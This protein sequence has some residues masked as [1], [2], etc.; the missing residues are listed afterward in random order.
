MFRLSVMS[1]TLL[2]LSSG[3][4]LADITADDVWQS[5][6]ARLSDLGYE[7]SGTPERDGDRL[8]VPDIRLSQTLADDGGR[9]ELRI[10]R[11]AFADRDD[12]TVAVIYPETMPMEVVVTPEEGETVTAM[13]TLSHDALSIIASGTAER[14]GYAYEGDSLRLALGEVT[15]DG[16]AM[17]G[18]NGELRFDDVSGTS[19][20]AVEAGVRRSAQTLVSGAMS[21]AVTAEPPEEEEEGTL[22]LEGR[23]DSLALDTR[24][25]APVDTGL[26]DL[27][28]ALNAG[29][30][31][32]AQLVFGAGESL[33]VV[34]DEEGTSRATSRSA[35]SGLEL[36][37]SDEG[38]VT[39]FDSTGTAGRLEG[40]D[41]PFPVA[42]EAEKAAARLV[43]PVA[44]DDASQEFEL[45]VDLSD[46]SVSEEIWA[47]IDPEG[48]LPR[49][50]ASL[51]LALSGRGQLRVDIFDESAV[52]ALE[53]GD[54][55]GFAP[56]RLV[57]ERLLLELAGA[58]LTGTGAVDIE[59]DESEGLEVPAAEG[60]ID[61]QL[62]GGNRLLDRLVAIGLLS[63]D[64]A[65]TARMMAAMFAR[66]A[67]GEADRLT[68]RI[69]I[70]RDGSVT[71]NGQRMR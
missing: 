18:L 11:I 26:E 27:A 56:E 29:F 66:P 14:I 58:T 10:G 45:S 41:L 55:T 6:Q 28:A 42:Y 3:A 70:E 31:V 17:D 65:A 53:A 39:A 35:G 37:L 48:T 24:M 43:L 52:E 16:E 15:V 67:E 23:A 62:D 68:S 69:E 25:T 61:L 59:P 33:T 7:V 64:Q 63:Q 34:T 4:G 44:R 49:D 9:A 40:G 19:E 2:A 60:A 71:V 30:A 50:P 57:V 22:R 8:V 12:G 32:D 5:W 1:A 13:L 51:A 46:V 21:Y 54:R 36:A 20:S 38:L 47:Q